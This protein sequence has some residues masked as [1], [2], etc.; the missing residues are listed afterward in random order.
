MESLFENRE[1]WRGWLEENG[2]SADSVWIIMY[3]KHTGRKCIL[4]GEAL[5]EALC[6]GW[7]DGKI[8]RINDEY[9]IQLY[10]PR[11]LGSRWSKYN[12]D[13]VE[14]LKKEGKM[15]QAGLDAY[16]VI[17]KNP[18]LAYDSRR[19][20]GI[21]E[22]P[23]ELLTALKSNKKAFDNFMNFPPSAK[24]MYIEWYKYAKQDKTRIART[25]RIIR[26]SEDNQRPGML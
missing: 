14:K 7:I 15:T 26:F 13:R 11:R 24:R 22:I 1:E 10:T 16:N 5:E 12:I 21:P 25:A 3:K 17:F 4:Y 19:K 9:Y 2:S 8:K 23:E 20:P 18:E 6:F